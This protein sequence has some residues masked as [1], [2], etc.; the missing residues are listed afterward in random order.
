MG[1]RLART[2]APRRVHLVN[3]HDRKA[4][5]CRPGPDI[6]PELV[7][8]AAWVIREMPSAPE[9]DQVAAVIQLLAALVVALADRSAR[10]AQ[11]LVLLL[12]RLRR[13]SRIA[14]AAR[15]LPGPARAVRQ[16]ARTAEL[17][18]ACHRSGAPQ[19]AVPGDPKCRRALAR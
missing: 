14:A 16:H 3:R 4:A 11:V 10:R 9:H 15:R 5:R 8:R 7:A 13:Q 19:A 18:E 17:V 2:E 1:T 12:A 6:C